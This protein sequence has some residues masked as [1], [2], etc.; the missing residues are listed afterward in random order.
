MAKNIL[1]R[2]LAILLPFF[3]FLVLAEVGLRVYLSYNTFYDVEMSRYANAL[4]KESLN[5]E[6]GHEHRPGKTLHVMDV[7]VSINADGFRDR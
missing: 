3:I 5:P 4:K 2:L 7:D 6:I 1:F